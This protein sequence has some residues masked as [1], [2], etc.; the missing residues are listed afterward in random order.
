MHVIYTRNLVNDA[1][2]YDLYRC[3]ISMM[4]YKVYW[5]L[6]IYNTGSYTRKVASFDGFLSLVASE[7]V[8]FTT[9]GAVSV[10]ISPK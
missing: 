9:F 2:V 10:K 4:T 5:V 6:I 7:V 3:F 1:M 8:I